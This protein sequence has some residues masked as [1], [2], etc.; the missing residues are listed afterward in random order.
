MIGDKRRWRAYKAR[1]RQLPAN[2]RAA[3]EA[4]ERYLMFFGAADGDTAASMYEDLIDLFERAA[5]DGTPIREIVG[6]DPVDFVDTFI[7]NYSKGGWI[8]RERERLT[9]G[10][11]R[12]EGLDEGKRS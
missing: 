1:T 5:A 4:L 6:A 3:V 12:A 9:N 11:E 2:Y 10:I 8:T 7:Q